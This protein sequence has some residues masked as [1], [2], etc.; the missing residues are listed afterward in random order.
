MTRHCSVILCLA[1]AALVALGLI[2]LTSTG[3]W[4]KGFGP[5]HLPYHFLS[6]QAI[7]VVVGLA[8]AVFA[9]R[10]PLEMSRK[11]APWLLAVACVLLVLCFVPGI[12]DPQ[13]GSN[14][15]IKV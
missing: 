15:W 8:A 7:M 3:T 5:D 12:A 4:A 14:R 10:F 6:R 1:V 2:M 11:S 13:Y 9:S